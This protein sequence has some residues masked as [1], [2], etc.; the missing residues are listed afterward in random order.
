MRAPV[1][2]GQPEAVVR[3]HHDVRAPLARRAVQR[4]RHQVDPR[5]HLRTRGTRA[6]RER[7]VVRERTERVRVLHVHPAR[8]TQLGRVQRARV[9][10][11]DLH[12]EGR[13]TRPDHVHHVA[14]HVPVHVE[15]P[16]P[17]AQTPAHRH[18]LRAGGRLVQ[19]RRHHPE[20]G[21]VT[22]HRLERQ[23]RLE[24]PLRDLRLVRRVRRVPPGVLQHVAPEHRGEVCVVVPLPDERPHRRVQLRKP[25]Q[26]GGRRGL[27][28]LPADAQ[29]RAQTDVLRHRAVHQ[30]LDARQALP[31]EARVL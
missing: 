8:V 28:H 29:R 14:V 26:L 11:N 1:A 30:L 3:P 13:G 16:P 17:L 22:H 20:P 10:H 2:R 6:R 4:K 18:R 27:G 12:P 21:Q 7:T 9:P 19:Q 24:T 23:H 15:H 25:P 31:P 5:H